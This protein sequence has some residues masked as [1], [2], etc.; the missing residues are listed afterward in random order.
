MLLDNIPGVP[1]VGEKN[2]KETYCTIW[3]YWR[4]SLP[5]THELKG[6]QK[7]NFENFA[8]QALLSKKTSNYHSGCSSRV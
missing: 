5:H 2:C 8:D 7:E 3:F 1:G 6:K 4:T